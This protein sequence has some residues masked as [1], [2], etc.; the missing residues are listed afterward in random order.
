VDGGDWGSAAL[1]L[2][3]GDGKPG[4]PAPGVCEPTAESGVTSLMAC[5]NGS[6]R[7]IWV[8]SGDRDV[9]RLYATGPDGALGDVPMYR[10]L[11]LASRR[12]TTAASSED[13]EIKAPEL[14]EAGGLLR[15]AARSREL[16]L[17]R[18]YRAVGGWWRWRR[19]I[20][21]SVLRAGSGRRG[22]DVTDRSFTQ[23][24]VEVVKQSG[25][26][27]RSGGV[28]T[29]CPRRAPLV[30]HSGQVPRRLVSVLVLLALGAPG[31]T[32]VAPDSV[33]V[34]DLRPA[35]PAPVRAS[36]PAPERVTAHQPSG[37]S[38]LVRT[39]RHLEPARHQPEVGP[40]RQ[41]RTPPASPHDT[42]PR[43]AVPPPGLPNA[44]RPRPQP[45]YTRPSS[46]PAPRPRPVR[47]QPGPD[48]MRDLCRQAEGVAA[49]GVVSL[50]H[51]HFG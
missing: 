10:A 26:V 28:A 25:P 17:D 5:T 7:G 44:E 15:E 19:P 33:V 20:L 46:R 49:P 14:A 47:P 3:T 48:Q 43:P 45:Q 42:A 21:N 16:E 35:S 37:H 32:T 6:P 36:G 51:Q 11:L 22:R 40:E 2:R 38:A 12:L 18:V 8:A 39:R 50:C 4:K 9:D 41:R 34:D 29:W 13:P 1:T 31:C 30:A 24:C 27:T 23:S